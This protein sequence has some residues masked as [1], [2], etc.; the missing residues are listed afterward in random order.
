MHWSALQCC[1]VHSTRTVSFTAPPS[2]SA[3]SLSS[4]TDLSATSSTSVYSDIL[5]VY[6]TWLLL[7]VVVVWSLIITLLLS[8]DN[9][10]NIRHK[11][12]SGS[13]G[14]VVD[15]INKVDQHQAR[16]VLG[17]VTIPVCN[18]PPRSPQPGHPS[19]GKHN[20]YQRQLGRKQAHR[21]IHWPCIRGLA[22]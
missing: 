14:S 11:W 5:L 19:V 20:E 21:T 7:L 4:D 1:A 13:V 16:L 10:I 8:T 18:Q 9:L 3:P 6:T 15:C 22:V 17:W 12:W 2:G